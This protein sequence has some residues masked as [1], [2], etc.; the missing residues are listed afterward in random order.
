MLGTEKRNA[1]TL[2]GPLAK[3]GKDPNKKICRLILTW[4]TCVQLLPI[5]A[6]RLAPSLIGGK[7]EMEKQAPMA[8][9]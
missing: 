3:P 5:A 9:R 1:A 6:Q 2:E 7:R 8:P 4:T